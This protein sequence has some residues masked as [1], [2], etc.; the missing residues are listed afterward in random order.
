MNR[1]IARSMLVILSIATLCI[2]MAPTVQ[3]QDNSC[4]TA[5]AAGNWGFI[6]SGTI[7]LPTGPVPA[8][9][10]ARGS[11]D[12]QGNGTSGTTATEARNVGGAFANETVT[13]SWTVDSDCTGTLTVNAFES[14]VLVRISILSLVFVDNMR[15]VLL[16]QQSLTLPGGATLPVVI[17]ATGKRVFTD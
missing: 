17:T 8:A 10:V 16:V 13:A 15:E 5:K 6:L 14:G 3:A 11:F 2:S 4:S 1:N 9:A 12:T 7:L